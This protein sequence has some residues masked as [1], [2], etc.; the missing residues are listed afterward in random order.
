MQKWHCLNNANYAF[1]QSMVLEDKLPYQHS[2]TAFKYAIF[3][4]NT[5]HYLRPVCHQYCQWENED[6]TSGIV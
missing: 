5:R 4:Q 3:T 6:C 2:M 1:A